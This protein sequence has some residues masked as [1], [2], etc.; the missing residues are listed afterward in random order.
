MPTSSLPVM[1]TT[2]F[3]L[4]IFFLLCRYPELSVGQAV[5]PAKAEIEFR[6][7]LG[8]ILFIVGFITY[9]IRIPFSVRKYINF[10]FVFW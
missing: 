1:V 2:A 3:S 6:K 9:H 10:L 4:S 7:F 8:K 5:V